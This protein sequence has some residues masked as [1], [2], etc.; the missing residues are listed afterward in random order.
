[1]LDSFHDEDDPTRQ[2]AHV[3]TG[4]EKAEETVSITY[5]VFQ[6]FHTDLLS[7]NTISRLSSLLPLPPR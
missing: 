1:M 7:R 3:E 6:D 5:L 4:V 2:V